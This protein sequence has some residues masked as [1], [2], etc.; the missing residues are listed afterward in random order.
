[1]IL[2]LLLPGCTGEA[3]TPAASVEAASTPFTET[4]VVVGYDPA[5]AIEFDVLCVM[6]GAA[7]VDRR[8]DAFVRA[9]TAEIVFEIEGG[10]A[11]S[12]VQVGYR[13]DEGAITWLPT[14]GLAGATHKVSVTPDQWEAD[15]HRWE[16]FHQMN[17]PGSEQDCYTGVSV[18]LHYEISAEGSPP[19]SGP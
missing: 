1:M 6:G 19:R 7:Q 5:G 17:T 14:T 15:L 11:N 10:R 16:F 12:G 18:S 3:D 2:M 13:V 8:P 4:L 9:G